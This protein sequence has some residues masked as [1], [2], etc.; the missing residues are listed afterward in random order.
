MVDIQLRTLAATA[1]CGR[2]TDLTNCWDD[3]GLTP[4]GAN[5]LLLPGA[6]LPES[7]GALLVAAVQAQAQGYVDRWVF[8]LLRPT[9]AVTVIELDRALREGDHA[10]AAWLSGGAPEMKQAA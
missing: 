5:A 2:H 7:I 3:G 8:D 1:L 9:D 6:A 10:V 4:T